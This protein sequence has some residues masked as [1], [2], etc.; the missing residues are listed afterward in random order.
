M[1]ALIIALTAVAV[2]AGTVA[3]YNDSLRTTF[4]RH[5]HSPVGAVVVIVFL[6]VAIV[7]GSIAIS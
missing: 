7:A 4:W 6:A 2:I 5:Y 1:T 3:H